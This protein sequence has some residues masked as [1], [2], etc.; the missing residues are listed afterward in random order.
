MDTTWP[1]RWTRIPTR[2]LR[3]HAIDNA[4]AAADECRRRRAVMV[5]D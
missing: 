2:S 4:R 5:D 3:Q 1:L